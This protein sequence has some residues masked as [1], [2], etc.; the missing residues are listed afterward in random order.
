MAYPSAYKY[1]KDHEWVELP[2]IGRASASPTTPSSSSATSCI[3]SFRRWEP[4]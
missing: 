3:S 1:T 2:A 4:R